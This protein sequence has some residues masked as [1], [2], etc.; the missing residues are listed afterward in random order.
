MHKEPTMSS[1]TRTIKHLRNA[2]RRL[3]RHQAKA[4]GPS[5]Q[6]RLDCGCVPGVEPLEP[7]LLMSTTVVSGGLESALLGAGRAVMVLAAN[8]SPN[9]PNFVSVPS[10]AKLY[11]YTY[12]DAANG[13][14]TVVVDYTDPNGAADIRHVYLRLSGGGSVQTLM[15]N[16]LTTVTRWASE[17][18]CLY[19]ISATKTS[20]TNGYRVTWSFQLKDN[21]NPSTNVDFS[22]WAYDYSAATGSTRTYDWNGIY[23]NN[24]VVNDARKLNLVDLDG[25]GYYSSVRIEADVNTSVSSRTVKAKLYRRDSVTGGGSGGFWTSDSYTTYGTGEDWVGVGVTVAAAGTYDFAWEVYDPTWY[26]KNRWYDVDADISNLQMEPLSEDTPAA[27]HEEEFQ[28]LDDWYLL[29]RPY[30]SIAATTDQGYSV[31]KLTLEGS[32][33]PPSGPSSGP[34]IID[35]RGT[36]YY[37]Y[38]TFTAR[39][40]A[41][42]ASIAQDEGTVTGFFTYWDEGTDVNSNGKIDSSEIDV[43]LLG[44][45]PYAVWLNVWTSLSDHTARRVDL[46]TGVITNASTGQQ[47]AVLP[48]ENR[49]ADFDATQNY[50]T[51]SFVWTPTTVTYYLRTATKN[52]ELWHLST[53]GAIPS[54]Q[55]RLAFNQWHTSTWVPP[56]QT[57]PLSPPASDSSLFID[58]VDTPDPVAG[59]A[60]LP[61]GGTSVVKKKKAAARSALGGNASSLSGT[62]IQ[63]NPVAA[64]TAGASSTNVTP[65]TSTPWSSGVNALLWPSTDASADSDPLVTGKR[66]VRLLLK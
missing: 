9:Q 49:I 12:P 41:G 64:T 18:D 55:A 23:D 38:G 4:G 39:L 24:L 45:D 36:D 37:Q 40:K 31:A 59:G 46:R 25:D 62:V 65:T 66:K 47:V 48:V 56:G 54:H 27:A 29:P 28:D 51:Y 15:Y 33:N 2:S 16:N 1:L 43:E 17:P 60:A 21:W 3:A 30:G 50:Y 63:I 44:H 13:P 53:P 14:Y 22:A 11:P 61:S 7:R 52:I 20:I 26:I 5:S 57:P 19:N 8:Q 42:Q 58:W 35:A 6:S 32:S 34:E 10:D